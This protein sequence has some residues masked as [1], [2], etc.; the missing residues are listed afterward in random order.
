[1]SGFLLGIDAGSSSVKT[2]LINSDTG[3]LA[4]SASFP[5]KEMPII[6]VKPGWAEQDPEMWLQNL[7]KSLA[8]LKSVAGKQ[9]RDIKAI[10]ISYQ[11]HGLVVVDRKQKVLRPSII[12]CDSRAVETGDRAMKDLGEKFC[13]QHLLNSPGNFTAS[14]LKWV[15]DNESFLYRKIFRMML[16]GDYLAMKMTGEIQTTISGLSEGVMWNFT[17]MGLASELL[18]YYGIDPSLIPPVVPAFSEQGRISK[19]AA[20]EL[21]LSSGIP[22]TYRA[23]DQPNNAFS[24]N[25]L[26]PGEVAA[27]AGTSHC[28]VPQFFF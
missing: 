17:S 15:M 19:L 18:E 9:F 28:P 21:G 13:L 2:S 14:K 25:V 5:K 1:M 27:T 26:D 3:K 7:K 10:G 8:V 23:G 12:W 4:A 11:M 16:P 22:V 20:R 24:L 6:S